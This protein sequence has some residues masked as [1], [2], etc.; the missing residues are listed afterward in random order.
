VPAIATPPE[1]LPSFES[2]LNFVYAFSGA[3]ERILEFYVYLQYR[4]I[5]ACAPWVWDPLFAPMRKTE[6]FKAYVRAAGLVDYWRAHGWPEVSRP[7]GEDD[8]E[9][10]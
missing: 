4:G 3:H 6:R 2:Y 7:V 10:E 9:C 8:F 1:A 5:M